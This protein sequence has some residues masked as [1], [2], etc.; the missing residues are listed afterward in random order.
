MLVY[1]IHNKEM[2]LYAKQKGK[3]PLVAQ[4]NFLLKHVDSASAV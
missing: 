2:L 1:N 4:F 3:N